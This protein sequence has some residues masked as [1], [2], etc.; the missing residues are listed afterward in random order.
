MTLLF[1][2]TINISLNLFI[3][4]VG[5]LIILFLNLLWVH[6][7]DKDPGLAYVFALISWITAFVSL[8]FTHSPENEIAY[9]LFI[10]CSILAFILMFIEPFFR[11]LTTIPESI[12][13]RKRN[14]T[15]VQKTEVKV[16]RFIQ[17]L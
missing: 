12:R 10:I 2:L 17:E 14:K 9:W 15:I 11:F 7:Q 3:Y 8:S 16:K 13:Q 1:G 5:S 4:L 6:S